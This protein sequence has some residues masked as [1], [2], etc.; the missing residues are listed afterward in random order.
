MPDKLFAEL[1][2]AAKA[3][4]VSMAAI[5]RERL[6]Q[7]PVRTRKTKRSLWSRMADLVM[8]ADSLPTDLASNKARLKSYGRPHSV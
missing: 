5:I 4:K 1:A 2:T 8:D 6:Q 7:K 3:R